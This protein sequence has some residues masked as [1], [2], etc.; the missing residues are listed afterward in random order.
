M[1]LLTDLASTCFASE[2]VFL[3]EQEVIVAPKWGDSQAF[4][5]S[6]LT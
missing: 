2:K 5:I 3:A 6:I 4:D 1:A